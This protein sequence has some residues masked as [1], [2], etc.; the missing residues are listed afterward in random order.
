VNDRPAAAAAEQRLYRRALH[1]LKAVDLAAYRAV[2]RTHTPALDVPLRR[3][4]LLA[5][6]SKL[7]FGVAA[8][9]FAFGGRRGRLA[10]LSGVAALGLNSFIVNVPLKYAGRR[11]R[12]DRTTDEGYEHR[13]VDMPSS[14][15]FPSGHSASAFA[16]AQAVAAWR[17]ELGLPLR[18]LAAAV[19]YSRV[20]TGVHYP[21]DV[22]AGSLVGMA[23][24]EGTGRAAK[25]IER[26][27]RAR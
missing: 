14:T 6:H 4:S 10:A 11:A 13:H 27:V 7:S 17:P 26:R 9:L 12:P 15:S 19:A 20:H 25:L 23:I 3:L 1:D 8:A 16:F 2:E 22:L 21:G 24:G 5:N 18:L